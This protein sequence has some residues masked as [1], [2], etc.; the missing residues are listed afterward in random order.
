ME[1]PRARGHVRRHCSVYKVYLEMLTLVVA[2]LV[3]VISLSAVL[4]SNFAKAENS[5]ESVSV[6]QKYYKSI[7]INPGDT[8]WGIAEEYMDEHYHATC[9]YVE[10]LMKIN[11]LTTDEIHAGQYLTV[12]YYGTLE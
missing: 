4:G 6:Q 12:T 1:R 9:D 5:S 2:T 8:L 7:V 3:L 10:E 11:D